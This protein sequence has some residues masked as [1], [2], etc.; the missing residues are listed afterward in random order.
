MTRIFWVRHGENWANLTKEFSCRKI[1]YSLTER[2]RLQ[3]KQTADYFSTQQIAAVYSSPLKRALQTAGPIAK[4]LGLEVRVLEE[5]RE[6]NVGTLEDRLPTPEDW[7]LHDSI[8]FEWIR[9]DASR[10]LP[11]GEDYPT[12]WRRMSAG[13]AQV[14][15]SQAA[16]G[17]QGA[18]IIVAHG[19]NLFCTLHDLCPEEDVSAPRQVSNPNCGISELEVEFQADSP[20]ARLLRY[21]FKGHL[22]GDAAQ[23]VPGSPPRGPRRTPHLV[24][25]AGERAAASRAL[26]RMQAE[27][28]GRA[29]ETWAFLDSAPEDDLPE[30]EMVARAGSPEKWRWVSA[31]RWVE[32]AAREFSAFH[33]VAIA[34]QSSPEHVRQ[35][36]RL[37]RV[38]QCD[39]IEI[40]Q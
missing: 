19:G 23:V 18:N 4:R 16:E 17:T 30:A 9:G 31:F 13:L 35:A 25:L 3:A 33:G 6:L 14:A 22:S 12:L 37:F 20:R 27:P 34:G 38:E 40:E 29:G 5:F 7:T 36:A 2:G 32:R 26:D 15:A 28:D 10:G 8:L 21:A 11:G 1:D 39:V 24:Y